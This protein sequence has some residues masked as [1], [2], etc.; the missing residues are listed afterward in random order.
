MTYELAIGDKTYSSWSLRGWLMFEKFE[1]PVLVKSARMY[2]PE[3]AALTKEFAPSR[4][5]PAAKLDGAVVWDT[6]ALGEE[7]ATRHPDKAMWPSDPAARAFARSVAAEMHS[8]FGAVRS[9]CTMNLRRH[10][11][12][13]APSDEVLADAARVD[14][15]WTLS[16]EKFGQDGPWLFGQYSLADVFYAPMVTRFATYGFGCSDVAKAYI[17]TTLADTALRRWRSMGLAQNYIQPGYDLDLPEG[18][19]IGPKPMAA[20]AVANGPSE[21][22]LC[23]YSGD[24]V[25]HYL[26]TEGR[27][28]GF[29]NEFCR[30]KTVNDPA[31]WPAFM[32]L[33][34]S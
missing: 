19:W 24:P 8:G 2:Q 29:C 9:Q 3:F 4:L 16:R 18:E 28:F 12:S 30:D 33:L 26:E 25:T 23:P 21:N 31:A 7:L 27:I 17:D 1:L 34:K 14:E 5:V 6:L 22:E 11:P 10:Y 20:T 13:F 15:L 32:A